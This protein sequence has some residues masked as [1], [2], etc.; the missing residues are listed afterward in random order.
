M[1][2]LESHSVVSSPPDQR[3]NVVSVDLFVGSY[4]RLQEYIIEAAHQR[5]PRSV[6]FANVHMAIEARRNPAIA[7]AVNEADWVVPD[8]VPLLWAMRGLYKVEQERIA[9]MDATSTL[10]DRAAAE[11]IAVFF[12]GSTPD[13]LERVRCLSQEAYP[14]LRVA[15]MLSPPFRPATPDEDEATIAQITASGA[16]LV[17]VALGCPKQE[18]WMAR[19]RGRI[20]AVLL[21]VGGALPVLAGHRSRAPQWI[22]Q[23][24]MEW[25]FRLAQE[26]R[27]LFK[28]YAVT[29]SLYVYY[30]LGQF[31]T[32][33]S[34]LTGSR[35]PVE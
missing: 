11:G 3:V 22:Q 27:R 12:Y 4:N 13:V 9:G 34:L 8:G 2:F 18:L 26:P 19:M 31:A 17:F 20:P 5:E 35:G 24:G 23:A 10:L 15:G 29:N 30:L 33:R 28:R 14:A 6:C 32:R 25:L 21:G 1:S 16:G 7:K